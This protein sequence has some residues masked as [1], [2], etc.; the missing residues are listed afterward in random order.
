MAPLH[1][2]YVLKVYPRLSETFIVNEILELE[3]RGIR[4][5]VFSL[6]LPKD[7]RFHEKLARVRADV[8]YLPE[9]TPQEL[10]DLIIE[11]RGLFEPIQSRLGAVVWEFVRQGNRE[12]LKLLGK[13]VSLLLS[14]R[15]RGV[16][17]LHAHF[18]TIATDTA[19]L[20]SRLSGIPYSFTAHA[21][22]I[23]Q[24]GVDLALLRQRMENARFVV[25]VCDANR[26]HLENL[27][28]T[29]SPIRRIYNGIDLA[30]FQPLQGDRNGTFEILAVT[31]LVPKKGMDTLIRACA[32]LN[33]GGLDFRCSIV[34]EGPEREALELLVR[35]SSVADRVSM[36]GALPDSRVRD[37]MARADVMALPA[38]IAPDGNRDALP[39]VLLEAL[40]LGLPTVSTPIG[41]IAEIVDGGS[42][43]ELVPPDRPDLLARVLATLA[44]NPARREWMRRAGIV[45]A[46]ELFDVRKNVGEL[47]KQFERSVGEDGGPGPV[48]D[49]GP[50]GVRCAAG[51]SEL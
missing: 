28:P 13:A 6:R 9:P 50:S 1:V 19:M 12:G 42:V 24:E 14:L 31:R 7:G 49:A 41:G 10:F 32:L 45:R 3:R 30:E 4:V 51:L 2:G 37:A 29:S 39:T 33:Q 8:V 11:N 26:R 40:A 17:H 23:Y 21:K 38:R 20:V 46:R 16:Q 15:E 18:G 44:G 22:D 47:V 36:L 5:T 25:T 43:G 27:V 48:R 34:G 35:E